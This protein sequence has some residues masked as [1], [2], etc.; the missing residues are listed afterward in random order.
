MADPYNLSGMFRTFLGAREAALDR[1]SLDQYRRDD[2][3]LR[4]DDLRHKRQ[5]EAN[6]SRQTDETNRIGNI[7]ALANQS[8]AESFASQEARAVAEA[9]RLDKEEL[10]G[11]LLSEYKTYEL[12]GQK[13]LIDDP[14]SGLALDTNVLMGA[15]RAGEPWA[16]KLL[17]GAFQR[18]AIFT[19]ETTGRGYAIADINPTRVID[20]NVKVMSKAD[21]IKYAGA[22]AQNPNLELGGNVGGA[23]RSGVAGAM[24]PGQGGDQL[25]TAVG[26]YEDTG[27]MAPL[28]QTGS[29]DNQAPVAE[30][31]LKQMAN[32]AAREFNT[33]VLDTKVG[34]DV[35]LQ[36]DMRLGLSDDDIIDQDNRLETNA[37]LNTAVAGATVASNDPGFQR[38]IEL[39]LAD[40]DD[41][42]ERNAKELE[43][44]KDMGVDVSDLTMDAPD[45]ILGTRGESIGLEGDMPNMDQLR[46]IFGDREVDKWQLGAGAN[47]L[48]SET[49]LQEGDR[50]GPLI[51]SLRREGATEPERAIITQRD[52]VL[53]LDREITKH[54]E[55]LDNPHLNTNQRTHLEEKLSTAVTQRAEAVIEGNTKVI[56]LVHKELDNA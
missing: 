51:K 44:A 50:I 8:R 12:N 18:A 29:P 16:K 42:I 27:E 2:L 53:E 17:V 25:F 24:I 9:E 26:V 6:R 55:S 46:G 28:T 38:G 15:Y 23:L 32:M 47:L 21:R 14:N 22:L 19:E 34:S 20:P 13:L 49:L 3:A 37:R 31:T 30:M 45:T 4:R 56:E 11:N 41:P 35:R 33:S 5:V 10:A 36:A 48:T 52:R 39:I 54:V 1:E 40:I 7:E 43:I